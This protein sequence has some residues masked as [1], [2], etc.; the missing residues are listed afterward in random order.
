VQEKGVDFSRTAKHYGRYRPVFPD[1]FFERL[2]AYGIAQ[3]GQRVLDLGTGTGS[4]AR[5]FASRGCEVT[6]IDVSK[7]ML[8]EAKRLDRE[9]GVSV[10]YLVAKAEKTGLPDR[11]FD[12][13]TAGQCWH[14][15]D[16]P[17]AAEEVRRVLKPGG[18]LVIA[19]FDPIPLPSNVMEATADLI[20]R[21]N[22]D[23]KSVVNQ[24]GFFPK[25]L[26]DVA[27]AGFEGIE[28]F[29][30]DVFVPHTHERWR[31]RMKASAAIG[32][33]LKPEQIERFDADLADILRKRFPEE[34][35]M[36]RHRVFV[37]VCSAPK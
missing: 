14:W 24:T 9:A 20:G 31:G 33:S 8:E 26:R 7:S 2:S 21:H 19:H 5:A 11:S 1:A 37:V 3:Q 16:R 22:P 35:L 13:V 18:G 15:F 28:T 10:T 6:G 36:V 4:L 29:T 34:P 12:V 32:A 23:S 17:K 25:W 27:I 30:F